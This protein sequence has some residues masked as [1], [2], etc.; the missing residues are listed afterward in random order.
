MQFKNYHIHIITN[1][2]SKRGKYLSNLFNKC[3]YDKLDKSHADMVIASYDKELE[4]C[5]G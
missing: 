2:N 1:I 3:L 4:K 5:E